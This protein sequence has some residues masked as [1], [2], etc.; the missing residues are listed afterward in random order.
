MDAI[1]PL[2]DNLESHG[3][4]IPDEDL[5]LFFTHL[6]GPK[7]LDVG[8]GTARYVRRFVDR[9]LSYVGID[10]SQK[11]VEIARAANPDQH[12]EVMSFRQLDFADE[13]FDGIWCCCALG[14]E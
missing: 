8:S 13:T 10:L 11:M 7:I 2:Y 9:G 12:F 14:Q 1:A 3:L 6:R 4:H 5:G